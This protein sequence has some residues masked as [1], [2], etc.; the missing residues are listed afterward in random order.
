M[1]GAVVF[2]LLEP[3]EIVLVQQQP[4]LIRLWEIARTSVR[5]GLPLVESAARW[6]APAVVLNAETLSGL[7]TWRRWLVG[8]WAL[9]VQ[10]QVPLP[11][12][13]LILVLPLIAFFL[14][15]IRNVIGLETFGTFSPMLLALAFLTTGL[16][17]G[18]VIF[19][20]IVGLGSGLRLALQHLRLHLVS[21][22]AILIAVVSV[23]MAG[24]DTYARVTRKIELPRCW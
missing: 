17:W 19:L 2:R 8:L 4:D 10:A 20:I 1:L 22:V 7:S 3:A 5:D 6:Q 14:L 11:A 13:N 24:L 23:S 18:L 16:G 15:V 21:R 9:A 12:L